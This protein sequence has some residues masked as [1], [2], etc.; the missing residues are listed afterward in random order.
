MPS[1]DFARNLSRALEKMYDQAAGAEAGLL[2]PAPVSRGGRL[3]IELGY[4]KKLVARIPPEH[5][6]AAFPCACPLATIY[7]L[8]PEKL[9]DLGCGGGLDL[10]A[11]ALSQPEIKKLYGIDKSSGL[12]RKAAGLKALFPALTDRVTVYDGDL[13]QPEKLCFPETD[14]ILMNGSFNLVHDKTKFLKTARS[15]LKPGG[16][17]LLY[18]FLRTRPLPAGFADEID[19][20]LW[21]IGGALD[22]AELTAGAAAAGLETVAVR[23]LERIDPVF[24]A[25]IILART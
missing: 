1:N 15:R 20:W 11:C 24:R 6:A 4:P 17:L 13:N 23:E 22:R 12:R 18:D 2:R 21:N 10:I 3:L 16:R 8:Q 7:Q 14:L 9:V 5:L 25:E 19:N